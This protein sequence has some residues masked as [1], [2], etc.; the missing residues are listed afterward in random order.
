MTD[1]KRWEN[2]NK[3]YSKRLAIIAGYI[4]LHSSVLDIGC[5]KLELKNLLP[6]NCIYQGLDLVARNKNTIICNLN[7]QFPVIKIKFDYAVC[8]GVVEYLEDP[9]SFFKWLSQICNQAIVSYYPKE[10]MIN[11]SENGWINDF[12][13]E[14]IEKIFTGNGFIILKAEPILLNQV[15]YILKKE[16]GA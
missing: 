11:R 14:E 8:S 6:N 4:K 1:Q 3:S 7:E 16:N 2:L 10:S 12:Q 13:K 15:L 9:N 5:G